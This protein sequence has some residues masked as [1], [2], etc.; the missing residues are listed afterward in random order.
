MYTVLSRVN[1]FITSIFR[2]NHEKQPLYRDGLTCDQTARARVCPVLPVLKTPSSGALANARWDN[3]LNE[4]N[5]KE[6]CF[7]SSDQRIPFPFL[8]MSPRLPRF[9]GS[10]YS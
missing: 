2:N 5:S 1:I 9:M 10:L 7:C 6:S 4:G 8:R 3:D